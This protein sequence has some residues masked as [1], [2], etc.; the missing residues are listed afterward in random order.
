MTAFCRSSLSVNLG[1]ITLEIQSLNRKYLEIQTVL[2]REFLEFDPIVKK[3]VQ[4]RLTRGKLQ[5]L[6]TFVAHEQKNAIEIKPNLARA[7]AIKSGW[8]TIASELGIENNDYGLTR[9]LT[10]DAALFET[11][12]CETFIEELKDSVLSVLDE[13]LNKLCEMKQREGSFLKSELLKRSKVIEKKLSLIEKIHEEKPDYLYQKLKERAEKLL[14]AEVGTDERLLKELAILVDK[15][16]VT[17]E[18][19]RIKSHLAQFTLVL[20]EPKHGHGKLLDFILQE[21]NREWSTIGAKCSD[22]SMAQLVIEAKGEC[23]KIREQLQ[24]IE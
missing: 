18:I 8:D 11:R 3:R 19:T 1:L 13:A 5:I 22:S 20:D 9:L 17:E 2:P 10:K 4:K 23:E 12:L 14:Q 7:Q 21:L 16:D 6:L 15:S 24:N